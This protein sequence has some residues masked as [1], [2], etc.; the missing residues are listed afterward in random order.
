MSGLKRLWGWLSRGPGPPDEEPPPEPTVPRPEGIAP[1]RAAGAADLERYF[2]DSRRVYREA[3]WLN[4]FEYYR[5][6]VTRLHADPRN[7]FLP[8][9][10]L[11]TAAD[12]G[13]G[14]V[15]YLLKA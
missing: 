2:E 5:E 6:F 4:R 3:G 10:D 13:R 12:A 14:L 7:R 15:G 9:K 11:W 1:Y 8:M